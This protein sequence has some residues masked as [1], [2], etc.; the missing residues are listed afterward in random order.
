M[1]IHKSKVIETDTKG[2]YGTST[3]NS[4][5]TSLTQLARNGALHSLTLPNNIKVNRFFHY[6]VRTKNKDVKFINLRQLLKHY[7][8]Y[9]KQA[10][11]FVRENNVEYENPSTIISLVKYL[12][13]L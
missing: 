10:K 5:T 12:E 2:A 6:R 7:P 1:L 9:K 13:S 11:L 8:D 4:A 3:K